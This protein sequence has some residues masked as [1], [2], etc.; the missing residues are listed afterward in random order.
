MAFQLPLDFVQL[1]GDEK[2][3]CDCCKRGLIPNEVRL[4]K[5]APRTP[6]SR[7]TKTIW[8]SDCMPHLGAPKFKCP[9]HI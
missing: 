8:C 1:T 7:D 4:V 5:W 3:T 9:Y 6:P 2:I